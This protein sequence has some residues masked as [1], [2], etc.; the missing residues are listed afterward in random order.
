VNPLNLP[1]EGKKTNLHIQRAA[2][3][4]RT[5]LEDMRSFLSYAFGLFANPFSHFV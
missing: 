5:A 1:L 3:G 2:S 4:L